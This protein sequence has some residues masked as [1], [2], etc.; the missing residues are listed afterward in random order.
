MVSLLIHFV[1][2]IALALESE[3]KTFGE[4]GNEQGQ[5]VESENAT[6]PTLQAT[7]LAE[8]RGNYGDSPFNSR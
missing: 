2:F 4:S 3:S 5:G 7:R 1:L 8:V 6:G